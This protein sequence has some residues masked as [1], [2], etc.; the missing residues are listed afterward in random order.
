MKKA[1]KILLII[2]V[3]LAQSAVANLLSVIAWITWCNVKAIVKTAIN[4]NFIYKNKIK[5]A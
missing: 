4:G 2:L 1:L 3:K 5:E